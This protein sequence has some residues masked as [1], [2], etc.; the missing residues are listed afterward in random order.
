MSYYSSAITINAEGD[1]S[2][3]DDTLEGLGTP[4]FLSLLFGAI[5]RITEYPP[6]RSLPLPVETVPMSTDMAAAAASANATMQEA[7][8]AGFIEG[9]R[10]VREALTLPTKQITA[11]A[12]E[13]AAGIAFGEDVEPSKKFSLTELFPD[14]GY[15]A[16]GALAG[17]VSRTFTAP[18]DRLKVY[19]IA[20]IGNATTPIEAAKKGDALK[21]VKHLGQP[22]IEASKEL[23]RA[24]GIRSLFAGKTFSAR[25]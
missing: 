18:L 19:L 15:F 23:W 5:I 22:L 17:A 7:S 3:S 20:N 4:S 11:E 25:M 9:G 16:A 1:T 13:W 21:A 10:D 12:E 8:N 14:P 24:G 6:K 2:I